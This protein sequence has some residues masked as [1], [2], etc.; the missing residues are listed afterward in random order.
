MPI[1]IRRTAG[2]LVR[3]SWIGDRNPSP[4]ETT[5][6]ATAR[7]KE[8][9]PI[10]ARIPS[11]GAEM[12]LFVEEQ[13]RIKRDRRADIDLYD[14]MDQS[15]SEVS[16][17][18]DA[19]ADNATQVGVTRADAARGADQIV[20]VVTSNEDLRAFLTDV[21]KRL[22]LDQRAWPLARDLCKQ[23]EVFEEVV[24][25]QDLHLD[26]V[27]QLPS[28]LMVRNEDE[29]GVLDPKAGFWQLDE[30]LERKVAEFEPWEVLHFRLLDRNDRRYGRS[31]LHP[32]R[33]VY[34]QLQMIED[35]M[36]V[37]RLTR[38]WSKLVFVI[39]TGTL[40]PPAAHE[41]VQKIKS[42]HK[43]R[44][45][46]DLRTGKLRD[47]YNPI[48]AEEDI[49]LG[50]GKGGQSRVDQL[51]GDL[52]IG[53]LSDVEYLQNKLFGG[54][55]VP[56]AYLA[57]ERDVNSRATVT[58]QDIQFARTV[59]RVQLAL[60]MGYH[61][62]ADLAVVLEAD[63]SLR[64][65]IENDVFSI[66]LPAMQTIDEFREWET[67]R[68]QTQIASMM[69][70][71]LYVDPEFVLKHIFGFSETQAKDVF[72]GEKSPIAKLNVNVNAQK[73]FASGTDKKIGATTKDDLNLTDPAVVETVHA[74]LD[75][76]ATDD[77]DG[78][79]VLEDLKWMLDEYE[80]RRRHHNVLGVQ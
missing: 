55:K 54:L 14:S 16:A 39:D 48:A 20:Q 23:G 67:V 32:V 19:Y 28:S 40:P 1:D 24:V 31:I 9:E 45:M 8:P 33:R 43:K 44:R 26:R 52:N 46:I 6:A 70:S 75:A 12:F 62:L 49:F 65:S 34:K 60:R 10:Y 30:T 51:Y 56:K 66:A 71:Q 61:Q 78:V 50:L 5:T 63:R 76:V 74:I 53:N 2:D 73:S 11:Q 29:Y 18:L 42:E 72:Q 79:T 4:P 21:F 36:V 27:K 25:N 77:R 38:A 47:D 68:V 15:F 7:L 41:H 22:R 37:A 35:S 64:R 69:M 59:R 17:A 58:N 57:I 13:T 80:E 3:G